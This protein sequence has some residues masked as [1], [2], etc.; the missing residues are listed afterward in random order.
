[1]DYSY[2]GV[3]RGVAQ[4]LE[5][6]LLPRET[7]VMAGSMVAEAVGEMRGFLDAAEGARGEEGAARAARPGGPGEARLQLSGALAERLAAAAGND[8]PLLRAFRVLR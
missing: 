3:I 5:R 8:G 4:S 2:N 7:A 1:M 6:L